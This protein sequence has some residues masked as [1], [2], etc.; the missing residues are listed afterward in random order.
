MKYDIYYLNSA[1]EKLDLCSWPYM[2]Y[3]GDIF[4]YSWSYESTSNYGVAG[5]KINDFTKSVESRNLSITIAGQSE[6]L[7]QKAVDMLADIVE[8]DVVNMTPGKLFVN[9]S[10]IECY[11]IGIDPD[12]WIY[13][14]DVMDVEL[15]L[16][17]E[18]PFWLKAKEY[19]FKKTGQISTGNKRYPNR[20]AWR[21]PNGQTKGTVFQTFVK[22]C[23]FELTI[24]GPAVNPSVEIGGLVYGV[25]EQIQEHEYV[26]I[27]SRKGTVRKYLNATN[28]DF[29]NLFNSR[30]RDNAIFEKV[31]PGTLDVVWTGEFSYSLKL[32]EERSFPK[33]SS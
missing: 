32:F 10:Y 16:L 14:C 21:Y 7:Y 6:L 31:P 20:Y 2:I 22:P 15:T 30:T 25:N 19:I 29:E 17:I 12:K 9:G 23:D 18:Y 8:Y 1:G 13:P 4:G 11:I 33:W 5:G 24:N 28:G 27:D 3:G 26:I